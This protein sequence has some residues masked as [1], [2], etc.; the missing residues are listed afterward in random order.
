MLMKQLLEH[1]IQVC[2]LIERFMTVIVIAY[3]KLFRF[4]AVFLILVLAS[5]PV[6][7]S[8]CSIS[9]ALGSKNDVE[10]IMVMDMTS[11]DGSHCKIVPKSS[12]QQGKQN[13]SDNC[14]MAGCHFT[15]VIKPDLGNQDFAFNNSSKQPIHFNSFGLSADPYPPIKPPA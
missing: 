11:M 4:I 7:A 1:H 2:C 14:T 12:A 3:M 9:C 5:S 10:Q 6:L 8:V 15:T 13:Q